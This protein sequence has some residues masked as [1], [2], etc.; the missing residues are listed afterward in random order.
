MITSSLYYHY[1]I[2]YYKSEWV[3][4]FWLKS[5]VLW[6]CRDIFWM[7]FRAPQ[8]LQSKL[9]GSSCGYRGAPLVRGTQQRSGSFQP[10]WHFLVEWTIPNWWKNIIPIVEHNAA[11]ISGS[12]Q[13][14]PLVAEAIPRRCCWNLALKVQGRRARVR[15]ARIYGAYHRNAPRSSQCQTGYNLRSVVEMKSLLIHWEIWWFW[16]WSFGVPYFRQSHTWCIWYLRDVDLAKNPSW[17]Q[18]YCPV[19]KRWIICT[20]AMR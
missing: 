5:I 4:C 3:C 18:T 8:V 20:S 19:F 16:Q 9:S 12:Q 10:P 15:G 14:P 17:S 11:R 1:I 7:L 13:T 6:K 2:S